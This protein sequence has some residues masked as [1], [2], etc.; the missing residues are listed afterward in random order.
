[1]K[2]TSYLEKPNRLFCLHFIRR[3]TQQTLLAINLASQQK[4]TKLHFSP[5][6]RKQFK[7]LAVP[8]KPLCCCLRND[9]LVNCHVWKF[10]KGLFLNL[11]VIWSVNPI[12]LFNGFLSDFVEITLCVY[13]KTINSFQSRWIV[14]LGI[15][16]HYSPRFQRVIDKYSAPSEWIICELVFFPILL[17]NDLLKVDKILGLTFFTQEKTS[18][19]SKRRFSTYY[20][21]V[22]W[23]MDCLQLPFI[24]PEEAVSWTQRFLTRNFWLKT[25]S[26]FMTNKFKR[27]CLQKFYVSS[28]QEK[29]WYR[30][31]TSYLEQPSSHF[32]QHF[33][34]RTT[35]QALSAINL[36]SQQK[37][38][39]LFFSGKETVKTFRGSI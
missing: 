27:K 33:M 19:D 20:S 39:K 32:C 13:T 14:A 30:K 3:T 24:R 18:R 10:C 21:W 4:T 23:S 38:T 22:L 37:T 34:R 16:T 2:T 8:F 9:K 29:E 35:Q 5:Q 31:T 17:E 12:V 6:V 26:L 36:A 7:L 28:K 1:M 11:R 15:F 25:R